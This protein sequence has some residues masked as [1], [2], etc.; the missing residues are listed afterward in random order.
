[1]SPFCEL[2]SDSHEISTFAEK[3]PK[4]WWTCWTGETKRELTGP[5][6]T[7]TFTIPLYSVCFRG[8]WYVIFNS[9]F[10]ICRYHYKILTLIYLFSGTS[11]LLQ[12][13][14]PI[15]KILYSYIAVLAKWYLNRNWYRSISYILWIISHFENKSFFCHNYTSFSNVSRWKFQQENE[16]ENHNVF[17][18]YVTTCIYNIQ[19]I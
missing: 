19:S 1:M 13:I 8:I 11:D 15:L 18:W 12:S 2:V 4:K 3:K 17:K 6:H 14:Q 10:M 7:P 5:T 16:N 9:I